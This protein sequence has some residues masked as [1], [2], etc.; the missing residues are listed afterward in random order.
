M[1][2][3]EIEYQ[4]TKTSYSEY[5]PPITSLSRDESH[6]LETDGE[7]GTLQPWLREGTSSYF[8]VTYIQ[9]SVAMN[10]STLNSSTSDN[11]FRSSDSEKQGMCLV[12]MQ[13]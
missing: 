5:K 12:V 2:S 3:K 11:L 10:T 4:V 13:L 1:D 9:S 8:N 7:W 6:D